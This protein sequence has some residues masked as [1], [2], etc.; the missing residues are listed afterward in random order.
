MYLTFQSLVLKQVDLQISCTISVVAWFV[1]ES[2]FFVDEPK[3]GAVGC[4]VEVDCA[5][6][7]DVLVAMDLLRVMKFPGGKAVLEADESGVGVFPNG[8]EPVTGQGV[9][10]TEC[11][12][13]L[14]DGK[15]LQR[16][17]VVVQ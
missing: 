3:V 15:W 12:D 17:M 2:I 8:T 4:D 16:Y 5:C 13:F 9:R 7:C 1:P 10:W 6:G 11:F 14:M